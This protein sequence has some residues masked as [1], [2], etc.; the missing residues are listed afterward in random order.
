MII[1]FIFFF[2]IDTLI[3]ILNPLTLE[4]IKNNASVLL[5]L[6]FHH[7]ISCFILLGWIFY[8]KSVLLLHILT[9]IFTSIYWFYNKNLCDLTVHVNNKCGWNKNQ[10]FNDI[11]HHIGIKKVRGWNE[12][13]HYIII[14]IG[15]II[16]LYKLIKY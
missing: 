11:L 7:F 9:V 13:W 6:I 5:L 15:S 12:F 8:S 1:Y 3:D 16:S 10:P 14:I 4:C 2:I